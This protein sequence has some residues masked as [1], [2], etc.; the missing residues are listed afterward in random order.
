M[1]IRKAT[2]DKVIHL[3]KEADGLICACTDYIGYQNWFN[4][5]ELI[6]VLFKFESNEVA[7]KHYVEIR[8]ILLDDKAENVGTPYLKVKDNVLSLGVRELY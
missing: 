8:R 2:F 3:L 1:R 4:Y 5:E 6:I 7:E